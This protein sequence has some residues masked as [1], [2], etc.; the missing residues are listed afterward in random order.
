[1]RHPTVAER[2]DA[3]TIA[4][5]LP[6]RP[7]DAHKF[8]FGVVVAVA[9]SLDYAGAAYMTA[10]A[11]ARAG[12]G[13]V[14]VA[15]PDSLR[16]IFAGRLPEAIVTALPETAPGRVEPASAARTV[17]QREP[18]AIVFGPGL[19]ES[20][21]YRAMLLALLRGSATSIVIDAGALAMLAEVPEWWVD[22]RPECVLTP[23]G[24]EFRRLT[25]E[26]PASDDGRLESCVSA[27]ARFQQVVVL[28]GAHTVVAAPDGRCAVS[29]FA[30]P[31]L[32]TAGS[33]DV[34]AGSIAALIGQGSDPYDAACAAVFL[35]GRA[36]ERLALRLGDSGLL[37]TELPLEMA[38]ERAELL[39]GARA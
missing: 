28:K 5:R 17:L 13:M 24:G 10:L 8:S 39:A 23:H 31:L 3:R 38:L 33:G 21:D 6:S 14:A 2:L 18:A 37:A 35:H 34:L 22:A 32:A 16:P 27:A 1:M 9:G 36:G 20:D 30:N 7:A 12:A 19:K 15:V 4:A 26:T 25:G 29:P 11:A